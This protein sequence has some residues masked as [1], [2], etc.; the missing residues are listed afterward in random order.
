VAEFYLMRFEVKFCVWGFGVFDIKDD[1]LK[2]M[3]D[4]VLEARGQL[5]RDVDKIYRKYQDLVETLK[6]NLMEVGRVVRRR[7][8][9]DV[10]ILDG[11]NI[12]YHY[13]N[14]KKFEK[15]ED[16]YQ[17]CATLHRLT[18]YLA[19]DYRY[20]KEEPSKD[21]R[22]KRI[23]RNNY[24]FRRKWVAFLS[25]IGEYVEL[26]YADEGERKV[27]VIHQELVKLTVG[28][29]WWDGFQW[30]R[31]KGHIDTVKTE[32]DKEP[33]SA[34]WTNLLPFDVKRDAVMEGGAGRRRELTEL[35]AQLQEL[36]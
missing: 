10:E 16:T 7:T 27:A 18:K 11:L 9:K 17:C 21:D 31:V 4:I 26:M 20:K 23:Y 33:Q 29:A 6:E 34:P 12:L 5:S 30:A 3:S 14:D 25:W 28:H 1:L 15:G 24:N 32:L 13:L 8:I 22:F 19:S 36:S 35:L 2:M